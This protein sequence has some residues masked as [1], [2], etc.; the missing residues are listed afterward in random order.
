MPL[1]TVDLL[2]YPALCLQYFKMITF[3]CDIYPDKVCTL[4]EN[5]L[6]SLLT[7]VELGLTTFGQEIILLCCDFLQLLGN[8]IYGASAG[9]ET[10]HQALKPFLKLLMNL[11]L[12]R[13]INSDLL[14]NTSTALFVLICCYQQEYQSLVQALLSTQTDPVI[15]ERLAKAFTD[16]TANIPLTCERQNRLKFR[17]NFEK[18]I[19]NVHGFLHVK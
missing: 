5:L 16:L 6:K 19:V 9:G 10:P 2:K 18:F 17:D 12:S 8:Y 13:Q 1:M 3:I 7:S 14:P 15:G 11:I 4:P